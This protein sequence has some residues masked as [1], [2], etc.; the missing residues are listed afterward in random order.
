[1]TK[2]YR[3]LTLTSL[4]KHLEL[5]EDVSGMDGTIMVQVNHS[6]SLENQKVLPHWEESSI[7]GRGWWPLML[8]LAKLKKFLMGDIFSWKASLQK[9]PPSLDHKQLQRKYY[10]ISVYDFGMGYV[11]EE[12]SNM[13][14][15]SH[16]RSTTLSLL[17]IDPY[18]RS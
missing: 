3:W 12:R 14:G 18:W 9:L 7:F 2:I 17:S 10:N 6:M 5:R 16:D 8:T 13:T 4:T 15:A 11:K 1:M